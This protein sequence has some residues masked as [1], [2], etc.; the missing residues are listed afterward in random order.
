[1]D[2]ASL[3]STLRTRDVRLWI[4]NAQLKCS[5]PVGALDAGLREALASCKPEIMALLRQAETLKS[6]PESIVPIKPEGS[7]SPIFAV[8]GHAADVFWL[9]PL[10]R[11]LHKD[12]PV[13]GV[14]PAGLD[15][16]EP[17]NSIEALATYQIEQIRRCRPHGPYLIVGHC[18]GGTLAIEVARQLV[19]ARQEVPFLAL[20]GSPF[21]TMFARAP[22]L[23]VRLTGYAKALKPG[24]FSRKLRLRRQRQRGEEL[25][26]PSALAVRQR[27]ERATLIALRTY[28]PKR[29]P[30]N[31]DLFVTG[32]DWHRAHLWKKFAATTREHHLPDFEINELLLG[33]NVNILATALQNR[34]DQLQNSLARCGSNAVD[35]RE[36][37]PRARDLARSHIDPDGLRPAT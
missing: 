22:L 1:M 2:A 23:W 33:P 19:A 31:I 29:Y 25:A 10:A 18:S 14:Q 3:L 34:L 17:L 26:G 7:R 16:S 12:Q 21:P 6:S 36:V 37:V 32:D 13:I 35:T 9:L 24:A 20:I 27:V 8:S 5:A 30:G 11:H 15:G 28:V 4:E